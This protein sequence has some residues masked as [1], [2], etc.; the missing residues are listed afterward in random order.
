VT[1]TE[2]VVL[3]RMAT[4]IAD[5]YFG[6]G[7]VGEGEVDDADGNYYCFACWLVYHAARTRLERAQVETE[8]NVQ[9]VSCALGRAQ[10][11]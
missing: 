3:T 7:V 6:C 10:D 4:H 8:R 9:G 1:S 11:E 5:Q 2:P